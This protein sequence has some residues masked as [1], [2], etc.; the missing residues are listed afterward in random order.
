MSRIL[1][2]ACLVLALASTGY[3]QLLGNWETNGNLDGWT[4]RFPATTAATTTL[5]GDYG[6]GFI[7]QTLGNGCVAVASTGGSAL[8]NPF[9]GGYR[10]I[11]YSC[12]APMRA[13]IAAG[14]AVVTLDATMFVSDPIFASNWAMTG[15]M[16]PA[17][18]MVQND[19][20]LYYETPTGGNWLW[21]PSNG[22]M[23]KS[24]TVPI[25][26]HT[27]AITYTTIFIGAQTFSNSGVTSLGGFHYDNVNFTPEPATMG[28]LG[29]G[30][31]A[32]IRRKK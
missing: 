24:L 14:T 17:V 7:G 5:K 3:G 18:V 11:G 1:V 21:N 2:F 23:T 29:L 25:A 27:G 10:L 28:L 19:L 6:G 32:L 26:A 9:N 8:P 22:T 4:V 30:A 16:Y 12:N 13:T 15:S 20:G 31:L